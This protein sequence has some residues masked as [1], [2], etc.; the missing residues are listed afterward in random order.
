M[1]VCTLVRHHVS[2]CEW[3]GMLVGTLVYQPGSQ[4][5]QPVLSPDRLQI[6]GHRVLQFKATVSFE[7]PL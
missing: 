6:R 7:L 2:A 1:L 4:W 3:R 5:D